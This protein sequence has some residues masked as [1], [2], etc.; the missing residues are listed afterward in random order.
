MTKTK[1]KE[2][3]IYKEVNQTPAV[4]KT[5]GGSLAP[6]GIL[7]VVNDALE[8]VYFNDSFSAFAQM[9][10]GTKPAIGKVITSCLPAE[11][12]SHVQQAMTRPETSMLY[13][14][15][16]TIEFREKKYPSN[17]N[18]Q[19]QRSVNSDTARGELIIRLTDDTLSS[20]LH[21]S[22][23]EGQGLKKCLRTLLTAWCEH[24][25]QCG[26]EIWV[27]DQ[28]E[29]KLRLLAL[30]ID[31][32]EIDYHDI[33]TFTSA[34]GLPWKAKID[35]AAVFVKD[36]ANDP[37][38]IRKTFAAMHGITSA[39]AIPIKINYGKFIG[40]LLLFNRLGNEAVPTIV[41]AAVV[42]LLGVHIEQKLSNDNLQR[43]FK[44]SPDLLCVVSPQGLFTKVNPAFTELLGYTEE[45]LIAQPFFNFIYPEDVPITHKK[46]EEVSQG[47]I[48]KSFQNRYLTK[49]GKLVWI[50]WSTS[51]M[52]S[53]EG[54]VYAFGK[55]VTEE[56]N[57][58]ELI[59]EV[60]KRA[61]FGTYEIDFVHNKIYCSPGAKSVYEI[62]ETT[63]LTFEHMVSHYKTNGDRE[64]YLQYLK[65][66]KAAPA[67]WEDEFL[68]TTDTG[69]D[70][71][72]QVIGTSEHRNGECV[73]IYGSVQD[74]HERKVAELKATSLLQELN[75]LLESI[76]DGFLSMDNDYNITY[77][78]KELESLTN[79]TSEQVIG[80]SYFDFIPKENY[81]SIKKLALQAK[82]SGKSQSIEIHS[83]ESGAWY[84]VIIYPY[85]NG[86]SVFVKD[87]TEQVNSA[88]K[89]RISNE[90]FEIMAKATNNVIWEYDF[91]ADRMT[92]I[93]DGF[94]DMLGYSTPE[95]ED[96]D[97]LDSIVH[98]DDLPGLSKYKM[99]SINDASTKVMQAEYRI[100]T[101]NR[102]YIYIYVKAIILRDTHGHAMR[103]IGSTQDVNER[104][105]AEL[106]VSKL[107]HE[108]DN[109]LESIGDGFVSMDNDWRITYWNNYLETLTGQKR[110]ELINKVFWD[111]IRQSQTR[112]VIFSICEAAKKTGVSQSA[113]IMGFGNNTWYDLHVYP[114]S[115]GISIFLK[116][117]TERFNA[118]KKIKEA[119]DRFELIA[120]VTNNVIWEYDFVAGKMMIF[121]DGFTDMLG[122]PATQI[123]NPEFLDSI[124]HPD[125]L[126]G[127]LEYRNKTLIDAS[128]TEIQWEYRLKTQNRGYLYIYVKAII[129]R[130][131]EGRAIKMIGSTQDVHERK[132]A[133]LRVSKL[134]HERDNILESIGD[135]FLSMDNDWK[136]T[137]WNWQFELTTNKNRKDVI[138]L[139]YWDALP[140]EFY[141]EIHEICEHAKESGQSNYIE[142]K[143]H[144]R[145]LWYGLS[146]YP[147][148]YGISVFVK[149]ITERINAEEK[150]RISNERF[151]LMAKATNDVLWDYDFATGRLITIGDGFTKLLGYPSTTG[152][153]NLDFLASIVHPEDLPKLLEFRKATISNKSKLSAQFEYRILSKDNRYMHVVEKSLIIRN[154]EGM[155]TRVIGTTQ[156]ITYHKEYENSLRELNTKIERYAKNLAASNAE[157]EQFAYVASHDLQE[158][159]RMVSSFMG[160]LEKSYGDKL[161]DRGKQFIHF[162]VD[163]AQR[164]KKIIID[165][166][167]YSRVN[168]FSKE[169]EDVDLNEI[170]NQS[171]SLMRS[172][173]NDKKA[174]FHIAHLPV[175]YSHRTPLQ[176]I[177]QNLI[178]NALK[179]T[180][181]GVQPEV[182]IAYEDRGNEHYISIA[183]NGIGIDPAYSE[184]IFGL[185]YRLNPRSEY[186]GTGLGLS[187]C[188]RII[189]TLGGR[190]W[191]DSEPG[192]GSNF[193]FTIPKLV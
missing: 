146:V 161:D 22:F 142:L 124:A 82:E 192:K 173:I 89:I 133:E 41:P 44:Y 165:L 152:H 103:M 140:K 10:T 189:E 88:E 100:K 151:E 72:V 147:Y 135:G 126:P 36:I 5:S 38:V 57:L 34:E 2:S 47:K 4:V 3:Q 184:K 80:K 119:N 62:D 117:I 65:N 86:M 26:G 145:N 162:A 110:K 123:I 183:D 79:L 97:F 193:Q 25:G 39:T 122:Y 132:M 186:E 160:L 11:W 67:H 179:Y 112:D 81:D 42:S 108:R 159:L 182:T 54:F 55:D 185:F 58:Q 48:L 163:G 170:V 37:V 125:D 127:V 13:E 53:E 56:K 64:R 27:M 70:R 136:I 153:F 43:L 171:T 23:P 74:I 16:V 49:S 137:Y 14:D 191:V 30:Q 21:S 20:S 187:V 78:N 63:E 174:I 87:I 154:A 177:F 166:L 105:I 31:G 69:K 68:V 134:L 104:K 77:W 12:C 176:Q 94:T 118:E 66:G 113:Q 107:L 116:D 99:D 144:A 130:D 102:G 92:M 60:G 95:L 35:N 28:N 109:I 76:S 175:I 167:E 17:Y 157:L 90:R 52:L 115:Y 85:A 148:D 50:S 158:P 46:L 40:T 181:P 98:P 93:G 15:R 164:M 1:L 178:G 51:T 7:A 131:A 18:I 91:V 6:D 180:T 9:V 61:R 101:K 138:G 128:V 33:S 83:S 111:T 150:I 155:A 84:V 172:L 139:P 141:D 149:D 32:R 29:D 121:G 8:F 24:L 120:K 168:R 106:N 169:K 75:N 188:K 129:L 114:H 71:W 190:I 156:D 73:R 45:E 59:Y 143:Y 19:I 96:S